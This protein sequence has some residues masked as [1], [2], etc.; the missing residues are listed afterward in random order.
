MELFLSD[1]YAEL[2][3]AFYPNLSSHLPNDM[4]QEDLMTVQRLSRFGYFIAG[5]V[6]VAVSVLG[7]ASNF[8]VFLVIAGNRRF[9]TPINLMLL[10]LS[11]S[12]PP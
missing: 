1:D 7:I 3:D 8:C 12:K 10:S 2:D 11:L 4:L 9:R 6:L 5:L